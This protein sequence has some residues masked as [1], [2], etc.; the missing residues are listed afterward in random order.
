[1]YAS[2]VTDSGQRTADSAC[3][4][5][6]LLLSAV[7]CLLSAPAI[8]AY[9][10]KDLF[11]PIFG[12]GAGGDGR[13]YETT[14]TLTNPSSKPIDVTLSF[15]RAGQPNPKPFTTFV[16]LAAKQTR[17]FDPVGA[18]LLGEPAAFGAIRIEAKVPVLAHARLFSSLPGEPAARSVA[19]SFNAIPEQFS[20]GTGDSAIVQGLSEGS[21]FRYKLYVVETTGQP[22]T[23]AL[24][25]LDAN[26]RAIATTHEY[27][28]GHEQRSWDIATLGAA[29]LRVKGMNGNGRV[30]V[31]GA[32]IATGSQD[33][34]AYEMSFATAPRWRLPAG[35]IAAYVAAGAALVVAIIFG[36]RSS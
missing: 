8:A 17:R 5:T 22:L 10:S 9:S 7:C 18:E 16:K 23:F 35:E 4:R 29:V 24:S 12:R 34:T 13:H 19:S 3:L 20:A 28:S 36:R 25:L 32:Q 33:G 30:I 26:G 14:F 2:V 6:V 1:L 21:D 15:M 11:I 31:A 27:V